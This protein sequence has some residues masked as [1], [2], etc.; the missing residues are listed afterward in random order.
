MLLAIGID[1][2]TFDLVKPWLGE[3]TALGLIAPAA[4]KARWRALGH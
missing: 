2:A 1:G 3:A 4:V